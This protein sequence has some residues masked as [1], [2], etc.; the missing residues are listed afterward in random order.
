M[1]PYIS[2]QQIESLQNA[3]FTQE[4]IEE[5]RKKTPSSEI[6]NK[7]DENG[8]SYKSV[9]G[10][11][12]KKKMNLIFGWNYSFQII[13]KEFHSASKEVIVLGRM[14]INTPQGQIIREQFGK[15]Y[16]S[17]KTSKDGNIQTTACVNIGNGYK[18]AATDAFKKCSSEL[19]VCWDVYTQ[20]AKEGEKM[21]ELSYQDQ[22]V[23]DRLDVNFGKC[24]TAEQLEEMY[25]QFETNTE[26]KDV[27]KLLFSS[28]QKRLLKSED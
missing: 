5:I 11:F 21:P 4:Q 24:K 6:E 7:T 26:V 3:A 2:K 20:E 28:H 17:N 9:K 27:H 8:H 1:K 22:V 19:G 15:H 25:E 14:T 23:Y 10:S 13:E 12:M 16:L 18:A